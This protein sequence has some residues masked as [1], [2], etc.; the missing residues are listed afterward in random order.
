[1]LEQDSIGATVY[2]RAGASWTHAILIA[3]SIL[4]LPEIGVELPLA[5]ESACLSWARPPSAS[6][7]GVPAESA[8]S[9]IRKSRSA[10]MR[11]V[12]ASSGRQRK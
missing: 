1:M 10:L 12:A 7:A 2:A 11:G 5:E 8:A 3:D 6:Q 9:S 4:A